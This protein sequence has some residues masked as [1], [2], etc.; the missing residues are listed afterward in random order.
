MPLTVVGTSLRQ[1]VDHEEAGMGTRNDAG[2]PGFAKAYGFGLVTV[3]LFALSWTGQFLAQV[4]VERND[5]HDHGQ[6][7]QW[8]QFWPEFLASTLENW[9][10]EFLQLV[11]QALG[12][13]LL[14]MWGSSQ[15]KE[16]DERL[17]AKVD[18]LL[19]LQG[20]DPAT[21]DRAVNGSL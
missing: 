10:S 21:I 17:E 5:A 19:R 2:R 11:W 18:A 16:S 7:F 6:V 3:A 13:A 15:S 4:V 20:H 8:G 9:Q 12:L 1:G 14:L